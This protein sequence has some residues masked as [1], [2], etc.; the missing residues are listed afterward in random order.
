MA[1]GDCNIQ[2]TIHKSI[3]TAFIQNTSLE[4]N[5]IVLITDP[6]KGTLVEELTT[7]DIYDITK[8]KIEN[9]KLFYNNWIFPVIITKSE[10]LQVWTEGY[11]PVDQEKEL[12][13]RFLSIIYSISSLYKIK[14]ENEL[15]KYYEDLLNQGNLLDTSYSIKGTVISI[16]S[17]AANFKVFIKPA[18][19]FISSDKK[20]ALAFGI[21]STKS[22]I[23]ISKNFEEDSQ[24][25]QVE[26][27]AIRFLE[28]FLSAA[29]VSQ[30]VEIFVDEKWRITKVRFPAS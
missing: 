12:I 5:L 9:N 16:E 11:T 26:Y 14:E 3:E 8:F 13:K 29:K 17:T 23:A 10:N 21:D 18:S 19:A 15:K 6:E 27:V 28:I 24:N 25:I 20:H 22:E 2:K 30:L 4:R 1:L 7:M